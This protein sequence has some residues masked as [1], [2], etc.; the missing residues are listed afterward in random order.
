MGAQLNSKNDHAYHH[1]ARLSDVTGE[2]LA[3]AVTLALRTDRDREPCLN[4]YAALWAR[5]P[6]P[7]DESR[8]DMQAHAAA[9][10][11]WRYDRKTEWPR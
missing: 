9:D 11:H 3:T 4:D 6:T 5:L 1:A 8:S 2:S 10:H 7:A